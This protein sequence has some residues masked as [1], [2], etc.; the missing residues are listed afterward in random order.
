VRESEGERE[1]ERERKRKK[2][3]RR[4]R[5]R[6]LMGGLEEGIAGVIYVLGTEFQS[7]ARAAGNKHPFLWSPEGGL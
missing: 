1:R 5:K 6:E 7:S 4:R 3:R 2:R